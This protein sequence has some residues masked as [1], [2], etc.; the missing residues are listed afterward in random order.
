MTDINKNI[1]NLFVNY[2]IAN[3]LIELGF[4]EP[5]IAIVYPD[6]E[7]SVGVPHFVEIMIRKGGCIPTPTYQQ[8]TDWFMEEYL[9]FI[10]VVCVAWLSDFR[11]EINNATGIIKMR[12]V[13]DYYI[14]YT[15]VTEKV[16]QLIKEINK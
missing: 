6:D 13:N 16:I 1:K 9:M 8:V 7:I 15:E 11:G 3:S 4:K 10:N 2:K 12:V 5:C 14:A